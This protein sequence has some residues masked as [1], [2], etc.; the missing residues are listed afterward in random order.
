MRV[1]GEE[2]LTGH[3][4]DVM[5]EMEEAEAEE[6]RRAERL[7]KEQDEQ[8]RRE[9]QKKVGRV[10]SR[11]QANALHEAEKARLEVS[12]GCARTAP[13]HSPTTPVCTHSCALAGYR[14]AR[15]RGEGARDDSR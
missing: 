13:V 6:K 2:T 10:S 12:A 3:L 7:K 11:V 4:E 5:E 14:S 15:A 9:E 1:A 8:K